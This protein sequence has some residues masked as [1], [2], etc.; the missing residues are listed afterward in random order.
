MSNPNFKAMS[1]QEL[2]AYILEHRED[3]EAF[4]IYMDKVTA[5]PGEIFPAPQMLNDLKHFPELLKKHL[6]NKSR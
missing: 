6:Q 3:E 5:E 1:R 2:R 4:Y